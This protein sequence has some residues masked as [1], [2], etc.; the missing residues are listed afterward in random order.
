MK[1]VALIHAIA[2]TSSD[3]RSRACFIALAS[4]LVDAADWELDMLNHHLQVIEADCH[5][6]PDT[7]CD[8]Y[9]AV[10]R[11]ADPVSQYVIQQ[12]IPGHNLSVQTTEAYKRKPFQDD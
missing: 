8:R 4:E 7:F 11:H 3:A 10:S 12:Q 1:F 5:G 9:H 2:V 6:L